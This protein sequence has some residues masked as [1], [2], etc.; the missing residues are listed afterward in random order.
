MRFLLP[1]GGIIDDTFGILTTPSHKGIPMG[2]IAGMDWA[3]DNEAF[4]RSFDSLR[5]FAWLENMKPHK[6][7][8]LFVTIPD[9]V[10]NA[11]ATIDLFYQWKDRFTGWPIAFVAQDGQEYLPFPEHFD[12]LFIGGTSE[13]KMSLAA[14]DCIHR[15]QREYKRIHIGRV[16]WFRRYKHF[17]SLDGSEEFTCDGTRTR[18]EGVQRASAAWRKYMASHRQY[19][20]PLPWGDHN[21]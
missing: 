10:G 7:K 4:T 21:R 13:W 17:A 2:I 18:Y 12:T 19:R 15:A 20:L 6:S 3:A 9:A 11:Q 1:T 5:Y 16:N 8:C 14:I